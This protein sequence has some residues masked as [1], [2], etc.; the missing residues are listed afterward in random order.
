MCRSKYDA[1]ASRIVKKTIKRW[2]H[3]FNKG[4][5]ISHFST[6]IN[7]KVIK[8]E[9]DARLVF[10]DSVGVEVLDSTGADARAFDD[11][12][13]FQTP[14]IDI[15][16]AIN[17]EWL[18]TYWSELYMLLCDIVRHEIEHLTQDG[19][20][21]GNYK[22]GKPIQD[23]SIERGFVNLGFLPTETYLT[24]PK[25]V[26]AN[27]QGLRFEAKKRKEPIITTIYRYLSTQ[28]LPDESRNNIL[29]LWRERAQKIGG[30]P[31]F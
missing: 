12:D 11:D 3:D 26:D 4:L 24:L 9:V 10:T 25:E 17:P 5:E 19:V 31:S 18:P 15:D 28:S 7:S 6:I 27:L 22:R 14:F 13:C 2:K 8:F 29:K 20:E 23:D 1:I 30:I 21:I 16:I